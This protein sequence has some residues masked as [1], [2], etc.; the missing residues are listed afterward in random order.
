METT[1]RKQSTELET[2]RPLAQKS[3]IHLEKI[4]ALETQVSLMQDLRNRYAQSEIELSILRKEKAAWAAFSDNQGVTPEQLARELLTERTARKAEGDALREAEVELADLRAMLKR[5]EENVDSLEAAG[6]GHFERVTKLERK[7]DRIERQRALALGEVGF[8][9]EQLKAFESEETVFLGGGS[10]GLMDT[11][12]QGKIEALEKLVDEYKAE[13]ARVN[14]EGG[15]GVV[16]HVSENGKRKRE[17]SNEGDEESRRKLRVLQNGLPYFLVHTNAND[18]DLTQSRQ[19]EALLQ[20]EVKSLK[21]QLDSLEKVV[22]L[23]NTRILELKDNPTSRY[24]AVQK[25]HLDQLSAENAAL[26]QRLQGKGSSVPKETIDRM[27]GDLQRME[28]LVA[29]KE[30]RMMRLKEV[31]LPPFPQIHPFFLV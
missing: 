29:Q 19:S 26:L 12:R 9:K 27:R 20:K 25:T 3:Q 16:S 15:I 31:P 24:Q 23:S 30:K 7:C 28:D 18:T 6:Q 5:A 22:K 21:S 8:L 10:A 14:R 1:S 2:L 11:R 4:H 13:L 17:V